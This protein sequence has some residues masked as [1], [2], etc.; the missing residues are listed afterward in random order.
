MI[1]PQE[2]WMSTTDVAAGERTDGT[3]E[4]ESGRRTADEVAA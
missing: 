3:V 2:D 1:P 4:D